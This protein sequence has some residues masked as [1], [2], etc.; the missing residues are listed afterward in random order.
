MYFPRIRDQALG[1]QDSLQFPLNSPI[2]AIP[3]EAES[4]SQQSPITTQNRTDPETPPA[5]ATRSAQ[6]APTIPPTIRQQTPAH[7][8]NT[9]PIP[10]QR[11]A[12]KKKRSQQKPPIKNAMPIQDKKPPPSQ[13]GDRANAAPEP[14][15][16]GEERDRIRREWERRAEQ[17]GAVEE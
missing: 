13:S 15:R 16:I 2:L 4:R 11:K 12:K 10:D 6:P 1:T 8:K 7:S 5:P 3:Q 14:A 17:S 9:T